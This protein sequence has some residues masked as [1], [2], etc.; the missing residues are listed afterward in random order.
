[1]PG[2]IDKALQRFGI[3]T[4]SRPVH[5]PHTWSAPT[6]GQKTQQLTPLPDSTPEL[7]PA[8]RTR[9]QEVVGVLLYLARAIPLYLPHSV[10]SAPTSTMEPS[11]LQPWQL[12]Y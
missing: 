10:P 4:P 8:E 3:E 12:T 1:M 11:A 6:Y 5:A 9:L 2:Y 7:A